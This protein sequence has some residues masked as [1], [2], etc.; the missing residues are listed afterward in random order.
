MLNTL[1]KFYRWLAKKKM[2]S[3]I[4]YC[5]IANQLWCKHIVPQK[6][7]FSRH[8]KWEQKK[9]HS[10]IYFTSVPTTIGWSFCEVWIGN[11]V[12]LCPT[13][14]SMKSALGSKVKGVLAKALVSHPSWRG[15]VGL[16][17][18]LHTKLIISAERSSNQTAVC[19]STGINPIAVGLDWII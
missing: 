6:S 5:I 8:V 13:T 12:C 10:S 14:P 11:E 19:S 2:M 3:L 4:G 9:L 18:Q 7:S 1:R 17:W 16:L 15:R